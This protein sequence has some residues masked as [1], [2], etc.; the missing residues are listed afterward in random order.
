M[1]IE[2]ML[3]LAGVQ[4]TESQLATINE[5]SEDDVNAIYELIDDAYAKAN[6]LSNGESGDEETDLLD[7]IREEL[8]DIME[9]LDKLSALRK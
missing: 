1:D 3:A 9:A 7:Y 2:K 5:G 6:S 8:R 4:L